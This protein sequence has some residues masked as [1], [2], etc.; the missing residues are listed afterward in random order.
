MPYANIFF[1]KQ[2]PFNVNASQILALFNKFGNIV[3]IRVGNSE[4][5]RGSA[6][7]VFDATCPQAL[8][9]NGFAFQGRYLTVVMH[10]K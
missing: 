5:T 9:L 1:I 7:V 3:Q 4:K 8:E 2:L 6:F 10:N